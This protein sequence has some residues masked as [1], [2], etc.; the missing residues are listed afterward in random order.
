ML[1]SLL[2]QDNFVPWPCLLTLWVSRAVFT[3]ALDFLWMADEFLPPGLFAALDRGTVRVAS[4]FYASRPPQDLAVYSPVQDSGDSGDSARCTAQDQ[5]PYKGDTHSGASIP[6]CP[7][8]S[9]P[10]SRLEPPQGLHL[11]PPFQRTWRS[12]I[13]GQ[14]LTRRVIPAPPPWSLT[15][16]HL[17]GTS[18][19]TVGFSPC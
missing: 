12:M 3:P 6:G 10:T 16:R 4:D 14:I 7:A 17:Q 8:P 18:T 13:S 19:Q 5:H 11:T 15:Q 9:S 1:Q 2:E